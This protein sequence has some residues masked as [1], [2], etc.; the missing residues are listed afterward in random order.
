MAKPDRVFRQSYDWFRGAIDDAL[1]QVPP[2]QR[3]AVGQLLWQVAGLSA[4][5]PPVDPD[6]TDFAGGGADAD[7]L[8]VASLILGETMVALDHLRQA[9]AALRGGNPA[10]ALAVLAP[11]LQQIDNLAHPPAGGA[12]A[13]Y[14]A[15]F[16]LGKILLTLSGD[17]QA[18]AGAGRE[19]E[20]LARLFGATTP[21]ALREVQTAL[22]L[23]TLLV[24]ALLDRSFRNRS[25]GAAPVGWKTGPMPPLPGAP[26]ITFS[27]PGGLGGTL[28]F[29]TAAPQGVT[30]TLNPAIRGSAT[31]DGAALELGITGSP[32][33]VALFVSAVPGDPVQVSDA[34]FQ[35][36][37]SVSRS[38]DGALVIGTKPG[39]ELRIGELGIGLALGTQAPALRFFARRGLATL[40]P[41]DP[42][43]KLVLGAG[44]A[45]AFE[46]EAEADRFG[47]LRLKNGSGLRASLPIPTL[48]SGPFQLQFI[49]LGLTPKNGSFLHLETELTASFGV[50]LGPFQASVDRLGARLRIEPTAADPLAFALRPPSGLGLVLDAGIVKGGGYLFIDASGGEYAGV[51]ELQLMAIS[52]KAIAILT[53]RGETGFSLLLLI[54]G[55]FPAIQLSF[56]FTLTGIGG[57]IGVQHTASQ[58]ALSRGISTGALDAVLFPENPVADAPRILNTLRGLFPVKR[59][60]FVIGPM[61]ELGWGTPSLLTVRLGLLVEADKFVL[62]GQAIVQIPPGLGADLALLYLRLDFIGSVVF[63]PLRIAFDAK[64]VQSRVAFISITGQFAFRAQF[65]DHP[66]FLISAGGFH[67]RFKEIPSDI[68]M[69]FDRV[70]ASFDIGIVGISFQGYFAITSATIQAGSE[71]RVWADIG[72]AAI[73][74][75][76]GFDAIC[77]L[78]PKFYFEIDLHAYL[79]VHVFGL[80]FASIH[81]EGALAG[82]GRWRIAG[83]ARV[84]TPWPL[85]DFSI[86]IDE[87]W[88]SDRATPVVRIPIAVKLAEELSAVGNWSAQLP[89]GGES[90]LTLAEIAHPLGS[91]VFQQKLI[92]LELRL[93]RASGSLIEG[94]NEF[95]KPSLLLHAD[96]QAL[97]QTK[98]LE[99]RSD[100]FAAAQFLNLSQDEKLSR[101]SFD[102]F[103][104]GYGLRDDD[105]ELDWI[106][107]VLLDHEEADLGEPPPDSGFR[108]F[109]SMVFDEVKHGALL[110]FGAAGRSPL[111]DRALAQPA[112]AT[113]WKVDPV[114]VAVA[115]KDHLEAALGE[116]FSS[117]WQADQ[118]RLHSGDLVAA[119][120]QVAELAELMR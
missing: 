75:G 60:G 97:P 5:A 69:P 45:L 37:L 67:P 91:L 2:A 89:V 23:I 117:V 102:T 90:F 87:S 106:E 10:A 62:L 116:R 74:G 80:D 7:S 101:P 100:H 92:P 111:R 21:Q 58:E 9:V 61:L 28:A 36:G 95:R 99:T 14:P 63:D 84:H 105:F 54:F 32:A 4:A 17:A 34:A 115:H 12:V 71:L 39:P 113:A 55:Q 93:E 119:T 3:S 81:L 43:L 40:T 86:G 42:F 65:G 48:P 73:E 108:L 1:I 96:Q 46:V 20:R 104:A 77:Y 78:E 85:P 114:P 76:F 41:G 6:L 35:L 79:A 18:S 56:G 59:G 19:A 53:T 64:L 68:P 30:F 52:V 27:G 70:G 118:A 29:A 83:K 98:P 82:P 33:G 50:M 25:G 11:V 110:R 44:I 112:L 51:L 31:V 72:I 47:R 38:G 120:L 57:L 8:A 94:A 16:A 13:T 103:T 88:G 66:S 26:Q 24:G 15:A 49:D 109:G 107:E 22:G